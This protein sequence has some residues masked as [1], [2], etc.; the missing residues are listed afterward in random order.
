MSSIPLE[1]IVFDLNGVLVW[2]NSL[3]EEAWRRFSA[4]L[5]GTPLSMEEMKNQVHG[6]VNRDIFAY[7]LGQA[8]TPE[9]VGLLAEEK[10]T[11]YRQL[12]LAAPD[13]FHLS[14][15]AADFLD[16][17]AARRIPRA[18]ATSSPLVNVQ[19]YV[20]HLGLDRWFAPERIIFDRGLYPGKPAPDIYLEAAR[21][22]GRP[23]GR[24]VV[25]EDAL[26]GIR[27]AYEA[28][29]GAIVALDTTEDRAVLSDL[30]GVTAVIN[31]LGQ[32]PRDI[33]DGNTL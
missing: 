28:G 19:F 5:R 8:V 32:F 33:L 16:H 7:V 2:D 25:I 4:R 31:D 30:P 15:G 17:L 27:S 9:Q 20:K 13:I 1:G 26:A 3:H 14:T 21:A 6:R 22:L 24:L 10:E 12:A 18:I 23:P 11:I 29:A